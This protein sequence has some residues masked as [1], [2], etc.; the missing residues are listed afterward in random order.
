MIK[1]SGSRNKYDFT[2]APATTESLISAMASLD[3]YRIRYFY[4]CTISLLFI[5]ACELM[6]G[7]HVFRQTG[8]PRRIDCLAS[9]P[10]CHMKMEASR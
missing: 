5:Y 8:P 1:T 7:L 9:P 3:H 2:S 10:V 6:L 4:H